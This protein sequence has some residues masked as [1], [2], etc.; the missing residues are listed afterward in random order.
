MGSEAA[1]SAF[2]S[3]FRFADYAMAS[4]NRG[5]CGVFDRAPQTVF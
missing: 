2:T 1:T 5:A 3:D 4:R